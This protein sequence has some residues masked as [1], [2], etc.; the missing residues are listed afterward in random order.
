MFL[1][2]TVYWCIIQAEIDAFET[3]S[4]SQ[5]RLKTAIVQGLKVKCNQV[6]KMRKIEQN[7]Q[8]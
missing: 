3:L 5:I 2:N 7:I 4:D 6:I 1:C 8:G